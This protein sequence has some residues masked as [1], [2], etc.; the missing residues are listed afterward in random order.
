MNSIDVGT[1]TGIAGIR[2][3]ARGCGC[4]TGSTGAS[5]G[6]SNDNDNDHGSGHGDVPSDRA[7]P[8]V[9]LVG[10]GPGDPELLTVKALKRLQQAEV[11]L[12][13]DLVD[14]RLLACLPRSA[15]VLRVGK[16]GGCVSTEQRFIHDLMIR[17]ARAGARV[18]RLKGGDPFVFGRGGEEVDALREAGIEVEV[19][20]GLSAGLAAPA[21]VGVPVTDRR[22]T[23]G[24]AF[25]TGHNGEHGIA[26]DW[27]ALAR[28]RLTLVVYMGLARAASIARALRAG[29]L[30]GATPAVVVSAAHTPRQRESFTTLADLAAT[31]GRDALPSPALLVI[32]EVVALSPR[33]REDVGLSVLAEDRCELGRRGDR[34]GRVDHA[35]HADRADRAD[36]ADQADQA[37]RMEAPD[38]TAPSRLAATFQ[39]A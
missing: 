35:G 21:A 6:H 33:W 1:G 31:I 16:R 15:R 36:Q 37:D 25:V 11:V 28:S 8:T 4:V 34:G 10:A 30:I 26:P 9:S 18:V 2:G 32:G 23:P 14:A 7:A 39:A 3:G 27:A 12:T 29:G 17:E 5:R 22:C 20:N 19:I 13:D 24:V 38:A